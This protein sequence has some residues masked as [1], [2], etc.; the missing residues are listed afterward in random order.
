MTEPRRGISLG[1][2]LGE[3]PQEV[4]PAFIRH[5]YCAE[6]RLACPS[7]ADYGDN[8]LPQWD[9]GQDAYG[10]NHKPV[11]PRLAAFFTQHQ[12]D[13]IAYIRAAFA[14][15]RGR[16]PPAPNT[17]TH[18]DQL[19]HYYQVVAE[20]RAT[21]GEAWRRQ[22]EAICNEIWALRRL[23]ATQPERA[24]QVTAL[25][26]THRIDASP[27]VRYCMSIEFGLIELASDFLRPAAIEYMCNRAAYDALLPTL[28]A[29][30]REEASRIQREMTT[31][32]G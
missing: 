22:R 7:A 29:P 2:T 28:P 16:T 17:L 30:I 25:C 9:G 12:I 4:L 10:R 5:V 31:P 21:I 32:K 8:V 13:P 26:D 11:W 23:Y 19:S 20:S 24:I 27:L 1:D 18:G 3:L 15:R 6:Y 14:M